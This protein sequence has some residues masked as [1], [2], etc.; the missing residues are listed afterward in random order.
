VEE[1]YVLAGDLRVGEFVMAA[2]D[3]CRAEAGSIH[4]ELRTES[5]CQFYM[6]ASPHNELLTE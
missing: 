6:T 5:G 1:L 3:F 2:G 4:P